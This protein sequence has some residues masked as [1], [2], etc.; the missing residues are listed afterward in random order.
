MGQD[1]GATVPPA[2]CGPRLQVASSAVQL[3]RIIPAGSCK[4]RDEPNT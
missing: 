2:P 4:D 1:M 3:T